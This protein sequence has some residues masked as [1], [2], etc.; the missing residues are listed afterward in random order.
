MTRWYFTPEQMATWGVG[1]W[2]WTVF[3]GVVALTIAYFFI[4]VYIETGTFLYYSILFGSIAV[5]LTVVTKI[6]T[7]QGYTF[8][9]HHYNIAHIAM[10]MIGY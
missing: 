5:F 1:L 8:H 6:K 4:K 7:A 9:I 10:V 2:T 3:V